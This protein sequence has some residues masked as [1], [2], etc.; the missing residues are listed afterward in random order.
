MTRTAGTSSYTFAATSGTKTITTAAVAFDCPF[1]FN[2]VGGTWQLQGA[3]TSGATRTCT[4]T[5]GTLDLNNYTLTI[6]SFS[7]NNTNTR[8]IAFGTGNITLTSVS[9][10]V[11]LGP[12]STN[13]G[14]TTTGTAQINVTGNGT[15]TRTISP[16][17]ALAITGFISFTISAGSDTISNGV[18]QTFNN[19]TFTS[20]FTGTFANSSRNIFGNLTLNVNTL[21]GS[22]A[23]ATTFNGTGSQTITTAAKTLDFPITFDG[24]GGTWSMQDALTMGSGQVLTIINGTLKLKAGTTNT[25]GSISTSGSNQKYLQSTTAGTQAT[26]SAASGTNT[27]S[28][29][30]IKD[31]AATGGATWN[32]YS[33]DNN[34]NAGN[35][36]GWDFFAQLSR[37]IYT[38]RK[39]KVISI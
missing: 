39:N 30:T 1:N 8:T 5:A 24:V 7:T 32:A 14:L 18:G 9:G 12:T 36:T 19:L 34:F 26:L 11:F 16:G 6:G 17:N 31:I 35:N 10:T 29:L 2:G 4:L 15:T 25:I 27:V 13:T 3:L 37:Y 20:G 28:Y 21:L 23:S 22:G 38:R 33:T